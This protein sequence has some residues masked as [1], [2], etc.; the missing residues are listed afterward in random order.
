[1]NSHRADGLGGDPSTQAIILAA[2]QGRRLQP[3]TDDTPKTLLDVGEQ[4]ILEHILQALETNGYERVVIVTGFESEQI[5]D[6]CRSRESLEIEFVHSE[7]FDSTNNIYS[8]WLARDYALDGFTLINSDTL[9]PASSLSKLQQNDGSALLVDPETE[10]T[11]EEMVVAF[12]GDDIEAIG[13]D[14]SGGAAEYIGLSK[15]TAEDASVLFEHI[16]DFIEQ[17]EVNGWYEGAFDR[18]FD[19]VSVGFVET[20][21][22]WIE[23][24]TEEDLSE[25]RGIYGRI[26]VE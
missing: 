10:Q 1:M 26:T 21:G 14:L 13:K 2:G 18:L 23:I 17:E 8:L 15:F 5:R 24:D 4:A 20:D 11:G 19:D 25:A 7:R 6:H 9:F 16:G 22:P 12:D 3:L